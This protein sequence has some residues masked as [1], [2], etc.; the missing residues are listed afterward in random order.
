MNIFIL[1][2]VWFGLALFG[3]ALYNAIKMIYLVCIIY[4]DVYFDD[5]DHDSVFERSDD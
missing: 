4:N 5:T 1:F 2:L 3:I